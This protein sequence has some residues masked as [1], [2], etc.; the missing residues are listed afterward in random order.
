MPPKSPLSLKSFGAASIADASSDRKDMDEV[1]KT[2]VATFGGGFDK[3]KEK[4]EK[5]K[6]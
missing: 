3:L 6:L 4:L 5:E 2:P 1:E